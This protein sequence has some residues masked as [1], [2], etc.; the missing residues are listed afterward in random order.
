MLNMLLLLVT[1]LGVCSAGKNHKNLGGHASMLHREL[2][3]GF[4][5]G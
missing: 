3:H 4:T 1:A 2:V 5:K